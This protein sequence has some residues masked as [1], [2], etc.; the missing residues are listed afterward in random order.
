[1]F[2]ALGSGR[3][4]LETAR[5]G[6]LNMRSTAALVIRS[7]T[8][9]FGLGSTLSIAEP[10]ITPAI[11][12]MAAA[13]SKSAREGIRVHRSRGSQTVSVAARPNTSNAFL[14]GAVATPAAGMSR[15]PTT[16]ASP[17]IVSSTQRCGDL[18]RF[19]LREGTLNGVFEIGCGVLIL[20]VGLLTRL[21]AVPMI[22]DM[23]GAL[24]ITK[25]P[26][27]WGTLRCFAAN[28]AGGTSST[29]PVSTWPSCAAACFCFWSGR[30]LLTG[31]VPNA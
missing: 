7:R 8:R 21:A 27:F 18:H 4:A 10:T 31:C 25:L 28:T 26:I 16:R 14:A 3:F 12:S 11:A 9:W 15:V 17:H 22:I 20:V 23:L 30:R 29:K 19:Q 13:P 6:P 24:L 5:S 1:M 2:A